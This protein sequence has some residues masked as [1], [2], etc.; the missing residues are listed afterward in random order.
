MTLKQKELLYKCVFF[1]GLIAIIWEIVIY[2]MTIIDV[3]IL[4]GIILTIG[5]L[6]TFL[7]LK[8]FQLL[9]GY[10]KKSTLYFWTFIQSSVSW[11]FLAASIFMFTNYYLA[12]GESHKQTYQIV[13]RSSLAGRKN[14]RREHKPTF[15]ILY[16]GKLKEL[17]F[18]TL[19]YRDRESYQNVELTIKEGFLGYDILIEKRLK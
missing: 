18:P 10:S 5:F 4:L 1:A 6:T 7:S 2:R 9:F 13:E 17:V 3:K 12:S 11:G 16:Q 14:H 8:D 15:R 19:Y